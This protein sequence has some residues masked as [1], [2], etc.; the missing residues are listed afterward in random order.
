MNLVFLSSDLKIKV[1]EKKLPR[2]KQKA[3]CARTYRMYLKR[4]KI[5][6]IGV[7][8]S[9]APMLNNNNEFCQMCFS[10]FITMRNFQTVMRS[11][12]LL[13]NFPY[14][15][16]SRF[17]ILIL[18]SFNVK[19]LLIRETVNSLLSRLLFSKALLSFIITIIN[20]LIMLSK[21]D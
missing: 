17:L 18:F 1:A 20:G 9:M 2:L 5:T 12:S 16:N 7:P 13:M 14:R 3:N 21:L 10:F 19:N 15:V 11:R 6:I 4:S 8:P